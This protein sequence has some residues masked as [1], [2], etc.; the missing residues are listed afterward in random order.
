MTPNFTNRRELSFPVAMD[1]A[2]TWM[3]AGLVSWLC[4]S[5]MTLREQTALLVQSQAVNKDMVES[6]RKQQDALIAAD[7]EASERLGAVEIAQ[8]KAGWG[9]K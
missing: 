8:A 3:I 4:Y 1:R 9:V 7:R 6:L 5:T 2:L